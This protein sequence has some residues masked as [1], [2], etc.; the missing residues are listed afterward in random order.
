MSLPCPPEELLDRFLAEQLSPAHEDELE[1]HLRAC[2]DCRHR[3]DRLTTNSAI[4]PSLS[5]SARPPLSADFSQR[6]EDSLLDAT[7]EV[8]GWLPEPPEIPDYE[9]LDVIGRGGS[10]VV[11]RARDRKL[12]HT[13]AIKI[14]RSR[15]TTVDRERF[16]REATTLAALR[17]Q[18]ITRALGAGEVNERPYLILEYIAGGSLGRYMAGRPQDPKESARLVRQLAGA[19]DAAHAAGF[20]HRDLKPSNVLLD[21]QF[22][23]DETTGLDYFVPKITD[24]GIVKDLSRNDDLTHTRDCLGTPSYMAPEQIKGSKRPIDC[25]TDVYALGALLYELLTGRPPFRAADPLDTMLQ[26]RDDEPV[27]PSRIQPKL[28]RDVETICLKCLEKDPARRYQSAR[29]LAEDL[30]RFVRGRP[31]LARRTGLWGRLWRWSRR[32]PGWAAAAL[33]SLL[34]LLGLAIGGPIVANRERHLREQA[35]EQERI[36]KQERTRARDQFELASQALEG[37]LDQV[38]RSARLQD[39]ALD[40][41]RASLIRGALPYY[42]QYLRTNDADVSVRLRQGR[43]LLHMASVYSKE[44]KLDQARAAYRRALELLESLAKESPAPDRQTKNSLSTAHLEYGRFLQIFDS[45]DAAAEPHYR[46]A[47]VLRTELLN[48]EPNDVSTRDNVA[49][50]VS[51]L[52]TVIFKMPARATEAEAC[53]KQACDLRDQLAADNPG[54][55]DLRNYAALAHLN[56]G[57]LFRETNYHAGEIREF[58]TGFDQVRQVGKSQSAA[59]ETPYFLS[60]LEGELGVAFGR[61]N[62]KE[63]AVRHLTSANETAEALKKL[64]PTVRKYVDLQQQWKEAL[65]YARQQE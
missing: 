53:L 14:L 46:R 63:L 4:T 23:R 48:D 60:L 33:V 20:V 64:Y 39:D 51:L 50:A 19:M 59:L 34:I 12:H 18:N 16:Q 45:A 11:Y 15:A 7:H 5:L 40:D 37:T 28:P 24:L 54:R 31:I 57:L 44:K 10:G 17:H 49:I 55:D 2:N 3:L 32:N 36:A 43:M 61:D 26:V 9:M 62:Q 13:V 35:S 6:L 29:L 56:L 47:L 1:K 21:S 30:D 38:L 22:G 27:T 41:V 25:R 65:D 8:G 58:Q 42:E 52:G